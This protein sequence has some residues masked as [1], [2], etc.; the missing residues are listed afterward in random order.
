MLSLIVC[1]YQRP[2]EIAQLLQTIAG[3]ERLPDESLIVD[4][5]EDLETETVVGDFVKLGDIPNLHYLRVPPEQRGLTRQ[6]NYGIERVRGDMVAFLD[7]DTIPD[8]DYFAQI[9][10]CFVRHPEALGIGGYITNLVQWQHKEAEV[11][12]GLSHFQIGQW[13]RREDYRWRVRR[14]LGLDST[15]LPGWMPPFFHARSVGFLPPDGRDYPVEFIMGGASAWRRSVFEQNKFSVYFDGY[16]L[17][18]DLEFCL[19]V[20]R[21]GPLFL[22]TTA[23]L[24]HHHSSSSRPDNFRYGEMVVRN[25]WYVWRQHQSNP[26]GPD[27]A[28]WWAITILLTLARFG[29]TLRQDKR[30]FFEAMGRLKG[31]AILFWDKPKSV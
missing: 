24:E 28:R 14:I 11:K 16:G 9:L 8:K 18:E 19:R 1:T 4:G 5:S 13:V 26:S 29:D 10:A 2:K 3:G 25:G 23:C 21:R 22:C 20:S 7:D 30:A 31:M 6:R 15:K 17:Y 12:A 27:R